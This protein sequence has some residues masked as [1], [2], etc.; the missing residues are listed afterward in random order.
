MTVH[1]VSPTFAQRSI[2]VQAREW[3]DKVNGNTYF[4]ADVWVD[5]KPICTLGMTYGYGDQFEYAASEALVKRGYLPAEMEGRNIRW[6]KDLGLDVYTT[7]REARKRE[8][9]KTV[10]EHG[11]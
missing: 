9:A 5:G 1:V 6:A 2:F 10:E 3:F 11:L 8:L 7:R 4:D